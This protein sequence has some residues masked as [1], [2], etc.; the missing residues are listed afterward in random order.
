MKKV[1]SF[2]HC[3]R[4]VTL[5]P[6]RKYS[7]SAIAFVPK[8][9]RAAPSGGGSGERCCVSRERRRRPATRCAARVRSPRPRP[10][11]ARVCRPRAAAR[12]SA[13]AFEARAG[14]RST[15]WCGTRT[16][17]STRPR[18]TRRR[19]RWTRSGSPGASAK[20]RTARVSWRRARRGT[21]P[22]MATR[23]TTFRRCIAT[24]SVCPA[25]C[26]GCRRSS[27][28][29]TSRRCAGKSRACCAFPRATSPRAWSR[30]GSRSPAR[31][32]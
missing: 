2:S 10:R 20:R 6:R 25:R 24:P 3:R 18:T 16:T 1:I 30:C 15:G 4:L 29:A 31:T 21:T 26:S 32:W 28:R 17:R 7:E 8:A 5:S 19:R 9:L 27:P 22:R 11:L 23:A 14:T 12:K 13:R